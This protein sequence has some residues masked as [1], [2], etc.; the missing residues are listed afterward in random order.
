MAQP[1]P[2]A[3]AEGAAAPP[4]AAPAKKKSPIGAMIVTALLV[5]PLAFGL[6]TM[7]QSK[8]KAQEELVKKREKTAPQ[9]R[10]T[11]E[12]QP[13]T[14]NLADGDRYARVAPV[15]VFE[16]DTIDCE[17]FKKKAAELKPGE[18]GQ[19]KSGEGE[20]KEAKKPPADPTVPKTKPG[21][22][23]QKL[24]E[25]LPTVMPE[26]KD[27]VITV[28]AGHSFEELLPNKGK[29]GLTEVKEA[30][31]AKFTEVLAETKV[32][33]KEVLFADWIMQ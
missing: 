21:E 28:L 24:L 23:V 4:A 14:V 32:P 1:A 12:M 15:L 3:P 26:M 8:A 19:K 11:F 10:A 18:E 7:K 5:G 33:V 27:A 6:F 2:A 17:H 30:L 22:A 9:F 13:I 20:G 29:Q 31:R 16:F 25:E